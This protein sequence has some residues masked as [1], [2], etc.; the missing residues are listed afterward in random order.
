MQKAKKDKGQHDEP[1]GRGGKLHKE[2][3][4][5]VS[6]MVPKPGATA[7]AHERHASGDGTRATFITL[8]SEN[9]GASMKVG[10]AA[11]AGSKGMERRRAGSKLDNDVERQGARGT[12]VFVNSNVQAINNSLV[13]QS[14]CDSSGH[15]VHLKLSAKSNRKGAGGEEAGGGKGKGGAEV[16]GGG[17]DKGGAEVA[18]GGKGKGGAAAAAA[19][20]AKKKK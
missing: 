2:L 8:A 5:G 3:T 7:A 12:T 6:D 14:S 1:K 11:E 18:G 10:H 13:L 17:K 4:A 15:G 20:A 19:A 9:K 16:A